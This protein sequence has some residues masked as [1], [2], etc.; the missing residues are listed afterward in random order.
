MFALAGQVQMDILGAFDYPGLSVGLPLRARFKFMGWSWWIDILEAFNKLPGL[1][2]SFHWQKQK[3]PTQNNQKTTP[4]PKHR[5]TGWKN[6]QKTDETRK[7]NKTPSRC[8][9]LRHRKTRGAKTPAK[10]EK[11]GRY[12]NNRKTTA[13][14][15]RN[16]PEDT[17]TR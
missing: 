16:Q 13:G 10:T 11:T 14:R 5:A 15:T 3:T 8:K 12:K 6:A 17:G 9:I 1:S 2:A 7:V 4:K